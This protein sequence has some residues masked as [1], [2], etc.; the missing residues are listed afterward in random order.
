[1]NPTP[2]KF[3]TSWGGFWRA[4]LMA[5]VVGAGTSLFLA[6]PNLSRKTY[7][8]LSSKNDERTIC[9]CYYNKALE[10]QILWTIVNKGIRLPN[11]PNFFTI[12]TPSPGVTLSN[13]PEKKIPDPPPVLLPLPPTALTI[14]QCRG[15]EMMAAYKTARHTGFGVGAAVFALMMLLARAAAKQRESET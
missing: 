8:R 7:E 6:W 10:V 9:L 12:P 13:S 2:S 1:M 3:K 14:E 11:C 15:D 4:L 5:V